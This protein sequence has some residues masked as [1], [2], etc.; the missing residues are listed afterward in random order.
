MSYS[1]AA[2]LER[3]KEPVTSRESNE[4]D[5]RILR[6][7]RNCWRV[8]KA[9]RAAILIDAEAYFSRVDQALKA[10]RRSILIIGWDFDA[11][12][13]LRPQDGD[14]AERLGPLLRR[15]VEERPDLE[16][17]VLVWNLSVL[18]APGA[19]LPHLLGEMWEDHPRISVRLDANHP[20]LGAQ[21]QKII[22]VD[23]NVAFV[24][25]IDLTV[26]RWDVPDHPA[27]HELRLKPDGSAY[28]PV[29]DMQILVEGDAARAVTELAAEEW[30]H[31]TGGEAPVVDVES[32]PWPAGLAADFRNVPVAIARTRPRWRKM[33]GIREAA[34]LTRDALAAARESIYIEAQYFTDFRLGELIAKR[35]REPEGP[36]VV[37][38]VTRTT[39][40]FIEG[41]FMNGNRKRL[42]RRLKRADRYRRLRL[43]HPVVPSPDGECEVLIHAKLV[44]ADDRFLR[45]GSSNLNNRST[46]LDLE[47]DLA[48]EAVDA[49]SRKSVAGVRA[50]LLGEHLHRDPE[51]VAA[52]IASERSLIRAIE[53]LNTNER[54]LAPFS[55]VGKGS[56]RP[57]FG[58]RLI[59]PRGSSAFLAPLRRLW[60][61][62]RPRAAARLRW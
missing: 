7:G 20:A 26:D 3:D 60:R 2:T 50:R 9:S 56:I 41:V 24:G 44:I 38:V 57:I 18:H 43:W 58:T 49:A 21:H 1:P 14:D 16:V 46:G 28:G 13:R 51:A 59:D 30:R 27:E 39:H 19:A 54:R 12:I 35:L 36:E 47:C 40:G 15:L 52:A 61:K 45:V 29:H 33:R 55:R 42:V 23:G 48:V 10:A 37:V 4:P 34:Q 62:H 25:G 6:P 22:A 31:A 32:D 53:K 11:I 5:L 8:E 17:R